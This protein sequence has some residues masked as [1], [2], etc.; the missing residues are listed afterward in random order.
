[1]RRLLTVVSV[2]A[3]LLVPVGCKKNE[4][5]LRRFE[6]TYLDTFDTVVQLIAYDTDEAAF[7][8]K[9]E[10]IHRE[11]QRYDALY[12]IYEPKT[13]IH[14]L[15]TVNQN[16]GVS[17][18]EVDEEILNLL[19]FG[20]E[21]HTFSGGRVNIASG[22]VLQLWHQARTMGL[23][24]PE[25]ATLPSDA[26]LQAAAQHT[27]IRN[28]QLDKE[29]GTVYLADPAMRLDVGAIA[30]G[31]A[32]EQ[33][34]KLAATLWE[35]AAI[36][37]GGNVRVIGGKPDGAWEIG[38][39]D[40]TG[41]QALAATLMLRDQSLVTSGDYQRYYTV[42]GKRYHHIIDPA[43]NYPSSYHQSVTVLCADSALADALSTALFLMPIAD[44]RA[45]LET[46]DGVEAMW[47]SNGKT[48]MTEGF[49]Q[50]RKTV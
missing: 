48:E 10:Q 41:E 31:Y 23:A 1:M 7:A 26:A 4:N 8:E 44:G 24:N 35:H 45:L 17:P 9:A 43:T 37:A 27:D 15:Y 33:V 16:A 34:A 13:G 21:V 6:R 2:L 50:V 42:A 40:P 28:L 49:S 36:S 22:A 19:Q 38:V 14:N 18:V 5:G 20:K 39:E 30:K 32:T 29:Q 11:L 46:F 3:L 12:D 47:I 25:K